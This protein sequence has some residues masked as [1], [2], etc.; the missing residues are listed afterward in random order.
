MLI[1]FQNFNSA[2]YRSPVNHKMFQVYLTLIIN[3]FHHSVKIFQTTVFYNIQ[4][5]CNYAYH[6]YSNL[7]F[8]IFLNFHQ[9][10]S[11]ILNCSKNF[12]KI[13]FLCRLNTN[14]HISPLFIGG[15][16]VNI[17]N[18]IIRTKTV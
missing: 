17:D 3:T 11:R 2:I 12:V 4:R 14:A 6:K 7:L 8:M 10:H 18:I 15:G 5:W 1:F 13:N 16:I 9:F